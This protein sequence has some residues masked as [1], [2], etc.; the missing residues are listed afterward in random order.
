MERHVLKS[1][2][3]VLVPVDGGYLL[4]TA[5]G[6]KGV[7]YPGIFVD[8]VKDKNEKSCFSIPIVTVETTSPEDDGTIHVDIPKEAIKKDPYDETVNVGSEEWILGYRVD[9][10]E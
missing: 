1:C 9:R 6:T 8:F 5:K 4:I 3:E 7:E 10:R 2:E